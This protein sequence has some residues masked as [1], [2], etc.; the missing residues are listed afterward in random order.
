MG[1]ITQP[2]HG[3]TCRPQTLKTTTASAPA[4]DMYYDGDADGWIA[5]AN[6]LKLRA[7]LNTGDG[8]AI[9]NLIATEDIID[10]GAESFMFSY[11][12]NRD[13]PGSRHPFYNNHY[14][15]ADGD[16]LGNYFMWKLRADKVDDAGSPV[17]DPRIRYYFYRKV[18]NS[19]AQDANVY[20]CHFSMEQ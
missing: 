20:S 9:D 3:E 4:L 10:A 13:N 19:L 14:E 5:Y 16:Y 11:G 12:S 7:Y 6:S 2:L 18:S 8:A 15:T 17:V 1:H